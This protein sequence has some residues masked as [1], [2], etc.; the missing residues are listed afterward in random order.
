MRAH[1]PVGYRV[2]RTRKDSKQT[3]DRALE[4]VKRS[5]GLFDLFL[6]G[7]LD[8]SRIAEAW[9]PE[10]LCVRFGFCGEEY[11]SL[12]LRVNQTGKATVVF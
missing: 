3:A 9:L 8:R 10:E 4:V 7:K 1:D 12:L 6:N 11:D 5:D 2:S